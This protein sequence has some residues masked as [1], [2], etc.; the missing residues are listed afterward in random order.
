VQQFNINYTQNK[1]MNERYG[2]HSAL[3]RS[4]CMLVR[5]GRFENVGF[6]WRSCPCGHNAIL[7]END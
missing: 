1:A 6:G 5:K 7:Q 3:S 4:Q 2:C